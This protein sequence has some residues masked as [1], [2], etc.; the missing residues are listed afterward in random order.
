MSHGQR[1]G[2]PTAINLSF[3]D[4][5]NCYRREIYPRRQRS[6][7]L[8]PWLPVAT[9]VYRPIGRR[10]SAKLVP[11]FMVGGCR[12]VSAMGPYGR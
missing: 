10:L 11:N 1:S 7:M 9:E 4:R 8:H 5:A 12:V 3:L 2:T 6:S